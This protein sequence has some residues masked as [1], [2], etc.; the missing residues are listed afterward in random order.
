MKI[1]SQYPAI[2]TKNPEKV[3]ESLEK[4]GFSVVHVQEDIL[5]KGNTDY[6]LEHV[7]GYNMD[8]VGCSTIAQDKQAIRVNVDSVAE[9]IEE[10]GEDGFKVFL[11]PEKNNYSISALLKNEDDLLIYLMEHIKKR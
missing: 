11:G 7:K 4:K 3:I 5:F 10:Y 1:K 9:A 8:V 2:I 6:V